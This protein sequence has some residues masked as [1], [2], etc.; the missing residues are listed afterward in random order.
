GMRVVCAS[1]CLCLGE[2]IHSHLLVETFHFLKSPTPIDERILR[3]DQACIESRNS[4]RSGDVLSTRCNYLG[5]NCAYDKRE[6]ANSALQYC[7]YREE[8]LPILMRK[9]IVY[10][11]KRHNYPY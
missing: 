10:S 9:R 1:V 7:K 3:Y 11:T 6:G 4:Q 5:L 2:D 8:R